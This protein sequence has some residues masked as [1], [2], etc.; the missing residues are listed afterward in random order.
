MKIAKYPF[1]VL[2]AA[3]LTVALTTPISSFAN[4]IWLSSMNLPI[5]FFS[6]LE[7]I[8]FDFQRLGLIL[9]GI[10]IIEFAIAFSL[11]GLF[12]K[13]IFDTK[14]LY[15]IA[16]AIVT[17]LTLF[18]LVEFTTQT[19]VLSGNRT[20]LGKFLHCAAGF[21]G[22]YL[23]YF[24][25]SKERELSFV[26]RTLGTIYAYLILGLVLN[27]V[28][29]PINAA[30]DFGF[31]FNE[32]NSSAQNALLRDFSAFF[33]ATFLF[34]ILGVITLNSEWFFSAG[35]VYTCA[36]IFNLIAIFTHGTDYNQIFIGEFLLGIFPLTLGTIISYQKKKAKV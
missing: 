9:Y 7:I 30:S 11:A 15:P 25:I 22:G 36:G 35:I 5:N 10:I 16:G 29:T 27:W 3:L 2:V 24:L 23:F 21:A 8:L 17:G 31:V 14:Y 18:L 4:I 20:I 6:S 19:E 1:A 13:Y 12:S 32:L 34:S 26:I 28:F 33:V